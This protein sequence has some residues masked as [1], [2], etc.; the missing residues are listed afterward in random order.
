MTY[1]L[2]SLSLERG[3]QCVLHDLNLSFER[4]VVTGLIGPNGAGKSSLI[5]VLAG[6]LAPTCGEVSLDGQEISAFD[7]HDLAVVRAVM[8]Q[9]VPS[10]FHLTVEQVIDLGLYAF[11]ELTTQEREDLR[12]RAA[13]IAGVSAWLSHSMAKHSM[14]QQQRVHFARALVQ[15]LGAQRRN[16][17]W[18]LLDEPTA[19]QDP[20]HQQRLLASCH[21]LTASQTVGVV[22]ALHDLTLAAQW[23]DRLVVMCEGRLIAQ[24]VTQE[25]LTEATI[26]HA[27]GDELQAH[28][29]KKPVAGVVISRKINDNGSHSG[30][31]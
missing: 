4:G 27:F 7:A 9:Q 20:L 15:L 12:F 13:E 6:Q 23:C 3:G 11:P 21:D 22:V 5:S 16:A 24:G 19:S 8:A 31:T 26:Q 18:L 30:A 14:G 1:E 10:D 17:G 2:K 29:I 25:V 28:V